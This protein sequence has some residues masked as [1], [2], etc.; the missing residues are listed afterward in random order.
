MH[1]Q[2]ITMLLS[3]IKAGRKDLVDDVFAIL[4]AEIKSLAGHQLKR[5][6][7]GQTITPTV[8]AHECY[9]KVVNNEQLQL[10]NTRHFLHYMALSMRAYLVDTLR[11]KSTDKRQH[12][13]SAMSL[14][15][16]VGDSQLNFRVMEMEQI[17]KRMEAI[18]EKLTEI[19]QLK[20]LLGLT[21]QEISEVI[22]LSER[23]VIRR[24]QQAKALALAI[25]NEGNSDG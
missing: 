5:L 2:S 1:E 17:F 12:I 6:S 23:Q 14:S 13:K 10:N 25:Y 4:Y 11:A 15:D 24:W 21:Y 9:L 19:L 18:D 8:L 22:D 20:V 16:C 7:P 3:E